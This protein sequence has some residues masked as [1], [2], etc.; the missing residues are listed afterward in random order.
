MR[1]AR[2]RFDWVHRLASGPSLVFVTEIR[3]HISDRR[4]TLAA[5]GPHGVIHKPFSRVLIEDRIPQMSFKHRELRCR[6]PLFT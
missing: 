3:Q 1:P 6:F 4:C 5:I 2:Y